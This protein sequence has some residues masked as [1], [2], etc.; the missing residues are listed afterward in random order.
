MP[1]EVIRLPSVSVMNEPSRVNR[2]S[3][4]TV[5]V[6]VSRTTNMPSPAMPRSVLEGLDCRRPWRSISWKRFERT[7]PGVW[8]V[9]VGSTVTRLEK[10]ASTPL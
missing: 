10:R 6:A 2:N 7:P 8:K 9:R 4:P 1:V 3:L 5:P